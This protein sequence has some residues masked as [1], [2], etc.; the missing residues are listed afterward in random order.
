[1][2]LT[3]QA[4]T[5]PLSSEAS[6]P[7]M[8]SPVWGFTWGPQEEWSL[9][10]TQRRKPRHPRSPES[11]CAPLPSASGLSAS[12]EE[13]SSSIVTRKGNL[14]SPALF[15]EAASLQPFSPATGKSAQ[16]WLDS[17][18]LGGFPVV[19]SC[20]DP[21]GPVPTCHSQQSGG[22]GENDG[23]GKEVSRCQKKTSLRP[24]CSL[25]FESCGRD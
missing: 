2:R 16:S 10:F 18:K 13:P 3:R 1:M 21:L 4:A 24:T 23:T 17:R 12:H 8:G 7:V 5:F 25:V 9:R 22:I 14:G 20:G 19:L 6:R 15:S 11:C